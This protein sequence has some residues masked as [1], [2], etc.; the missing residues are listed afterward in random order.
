MIKENT[1]LGIELGSTRIKAC[2][3]D[4]DGSVISSGSFE[5]ESAYEN[6]YWTYSLDSIHNGVK[7]CFSD[8]CKNVKEKYDV[9]LDKVGGI[10]IS[11]MMHGYLAF[12]KDWNLLTPFR[13]W[14]NTTTAK[15]SEILTKQFS[16][17]VPLRWSISHLYEA[18]LNKEEHIKNIAHITTL[19]GYIHYLLTGKHELGIGDASGVFPISGNGYD[20]EMVEKFD[21]LIKEFGLGYTLLDLL[22][23]VKSAGDNGAF[24]TKSGAE[25]LDVSGNLCDGIPVCPPEGDAGTGMVAT[26]AVSPRTGNISAGT[27]IFSMLVLEKPLSTIYPQIDMVTTP[28]GFP[29]AMVHCNNCAGELDTWINI[30]GETLSLFGHKADKN[31]LYETLYNHAL[32]GNTDGIV[33]YNYLSGEHATNVENGKPMYFRL[34][35]VKMN[36]SSF[37][38]SQLS[39]S[40]ASLTMG[41]EVLFS[42][43]K[44][45]ADSF[46]AHGGLFKVKGVAQKLLANALDTPISVMETAGE[47]GAW[48]MALLASYM[49]NKENLTLGEW[50]RDVI[51]CKCEVSTLLPDEDGVKEYKNF[52]DNFK[53]G[54]VAEYSLSEVE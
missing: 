17:N 31:E 32:T 51:F 22:P 34:P 24:L 18:I 13:T 1:Y 43:E 46:T 27:S 41:M 30:F 3:I 2:L 45:N 20:K 5:W 15:A 44:A 38:K 50:L 39:A 48:G 40:F 36:L 26:N 4:K 49:V 8:L 29:V 42:K 28:D 14:R 12:D 19:A 23:E 21:A 53:S 9:T 10:G 16:F 11:A 37:M 35:G 6:G 25:F 47:G 33:C 54:L 52:L 7:K